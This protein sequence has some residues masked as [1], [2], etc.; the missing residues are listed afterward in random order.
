MYVKSAENRH[1]DATCQPHYL[2]GRTEQTKRVN[3]LKS[4]LLLNEFRS[5]RS[6]C[7]RVCTIILSHLFNGGSFADIQK[8]KSHLIGQLTLLMYK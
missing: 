4:K 7:L 1:C 3:I 8:S 5:Y 2:G 6:I